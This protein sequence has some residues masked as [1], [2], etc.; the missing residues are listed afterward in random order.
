MNR[1]RHEREVPIT[2]ARQPSGLHWVEPL[3]DPSAVHRLVTT[4]CSP[5]PPSAIGKATDADPER[6]DDGQ[7]PPVTKNTR[8]EAGV[9]SYS[10]N[11][12]CGRL[13]G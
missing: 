6:G 13:V 8:R 12:K 7:E 11:A 1:D 9:V 2:A 5:S 4:R 10:P 3:A